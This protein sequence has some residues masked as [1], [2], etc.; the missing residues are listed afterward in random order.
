[1]DARHCGGAGAVCAAWYMPHGK[2]PGK[3]MPAIVG[4]LEPCVRGYHLCRAKDLLEWLGPAIFRAE[5]RGERIVCDDQVVVR[6]ARLIS[7]TGWNDHTARLFAADCAE[8]VLCFFEK[9]YPQDDRPRKAIDAARA[10]AHGKISSKELAATGGAAW[11]AS[12]GASWAARA[13][14]AAER[15]WQ[16][17]I[18]LQYLSAGGA[19]DD[20]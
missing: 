10:F 4:E 17:K 12:W 13:A 2:R 9:A 18:L 5:Y 8:H 7:I 1:M 15:I 16:T 3:W 6:Q 19:P 14:R 20:A 11:G